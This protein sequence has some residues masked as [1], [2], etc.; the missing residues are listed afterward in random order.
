MLFCVKAIPHLFCLEHGA[1]GRERRAG[2]VVEFTVAFKEGRPHVTEEA[3]FH[4]LQTRCRD[5]SVTSPHTN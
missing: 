3:Q 5:L 1:V 4:P 2:F